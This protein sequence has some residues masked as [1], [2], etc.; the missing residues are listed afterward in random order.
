MRHVT[1]FL[2]VI[3]QVMKS[4]RCDDRR[5][6]HKWGVGKVVQCVGGDKRARG[7][8]EDKDVDL[9]GNVLIKQILK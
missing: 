5:R 8:L 9:H 2:P 4:R 7:R 6:C 1:L 3:V